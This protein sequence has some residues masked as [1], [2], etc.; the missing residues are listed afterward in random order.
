MYIVGT[1]AAF[2]WYDWGKN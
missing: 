2:A 1:I